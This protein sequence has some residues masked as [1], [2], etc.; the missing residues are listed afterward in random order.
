M[1]SKSSNLYLRLSP[2]LLFLVFR[3]SLI[4]IELN[5]VFYSSDS[6]SQIS[7]M[8]YQSLI[9]LCEIWPNSWISKDV[10]NEC[11]Y[12][13]LSQVLNS[14]IFFFIEKNFLLYRMIN[15]ISIIQFVSFEHYSLIMNS[16][17]NQFVI[18]F[19]IY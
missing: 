9:E 16:K 5:S 13:I 2:M 11:I 18:I 14:R 12:S 7:H 15:L 6:E 19:N 17:K 4:P 8:A 10:F 1:P 3:T